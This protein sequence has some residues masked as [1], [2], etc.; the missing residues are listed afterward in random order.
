MEPVQG[1]EP[2]VQCPLLP[3]EPLYLHNIPVRRL[4]MV[5]FPG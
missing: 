1:P 2:S 3:R 4:F 5:P